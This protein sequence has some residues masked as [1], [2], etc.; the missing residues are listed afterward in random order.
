MK[1]F[2]TVLLA[3]LLVF[4]LTACNGGGGTNGAKLK[5]T[6]TYTYSSDPASFD[7]LQTARAADH[8]WNANFVDGLVEN[9]KYG[10]YIGSLAEKWEHNDDY[11]VWTFH[12][13]DA[14]W[15]TSTGDEY[16]SVAADD[17]V[18]GLQ[19]A[20]DFNSGTMF[21]VQGLVVNVNEYKAGKVGME[22]VGVKALDEKTVE[23]TLTGP[24]TYFH[25][26]AA[27]SILYPVNRQFLEA[28]GAGC[29]LGAPDPSTCTFGSI[30]AT[31]ILYCGGFIPTQLV[32]KS[33]I[34]LSKNAAYWDVEH[35]YLDTITYIYND[36]TDLYAN[37]NGL[38]QGTYDG[39]TL[40]TSWADF[41]DYKEKY[42]DY[43]HVSLPNTTT[44]GINFNFN[45]VCYDHT[46]H[47]TDAEK[48]QTHNAILNKNFR[49]AVQAAFDRVA[50]L[51]VSIPEEVAV[52][53]LRNINNYPDMVQTSDGTNYVDLVT[54]EYVEM[55]GNNVSLADAQD[56][57]LSKDKALA[58]IEEAKKEG[59]QF[60][61]TIDVMTFS[62]YSQIYID[63]AESMKKS[64]Y[65]NTDGQIIIEPLYVPFDEAYAILYLNSDPS[66]TDYDINTFSGW[67]PDYVDPMTFCDIYS[68]TTG[69]Y[70]EIIGFALPGDDE[71]YSLSPE[72]MARS[73]Q[74]QEQVGFNEYERLIREADAIKTDPDARYKAFAKADAYLVANA[75]FIPNQM[76]TR[77]Y[78]VS[79]VVPFT[80][81][82]AV[83]GLGEYK[84]KGMKVQEELVTKAQWDKAEKDFWANK[85]N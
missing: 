51:S 50:Y 49:L 23:Y 33:I 1:K 43:Y 52:A 53:M 12:L 14:K 76:Q 27:Y 10:H 55:T 45:R 21:L 61:V 56:P 26:I 67:G 25:T 11:T 3:C 17:F 5:N 37:I 39:A 84:F 79:K 80:A 75:L 65:D 2:L 9:D 68:T 78:V 66:K 58:Y 59:V 40:V 13:R 31:S 81:P 35:V 57:F 20:L 15:V 64:V 47:K 85:G 63:R 19:H 22:E 83:A 36:G 46:N 54:K 48:E 18:A 82:Y 30:D 71:N 74:I 38:E 4:G 41:N 34:E 29:K 16:A 28:Q 44:F 6:Y 62:D 72:F 42:K 8:Q 24:C 70:T 32:N 77:G 7:Y 69:Y 60:P 73:A